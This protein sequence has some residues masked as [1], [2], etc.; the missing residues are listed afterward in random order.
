[1]EADRDDAARLR[2]SL[3]DA[4]GA[5][6]RPEGTASGGAQCVI[7]KVASGSTASAFWT[8]TAQ[9]VA[10]AEVDGGSGTLADA[11]YTFKAYNL[12]A[13]APSIGTPYLCTFTPY[14]WT[15]R[16]G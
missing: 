12:G 4:D 13:T 6:T 10:G 5:A 15:F 11:G 14:R 16:N 8:M 3:D 1:M 2:Q 9:V 7:G